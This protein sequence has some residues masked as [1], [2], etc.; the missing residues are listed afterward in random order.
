MR[1]VISSM[2]NTG[3]RSL[4]RMGV[5]VLCLMCVSGLG[6]QAKMTDW[7]A[8]LWLRESVEGKVALVVNMFT[9][10]RETSAAEALE[11]LLAEN[12]DDKEFVKAT[13]KL[14]PAMRRQLVVNPTTSEAARKL[15][16]RVE[17]AIANLRRDRAY[18][19][20]V[21]AQI[22]DG[23][24]QRWQALRRCTQLGEYAVPAMVNMLAQTE[25]VRLRVF[26]GNALVLMGPRAV[27]PLSEAVRL[28]DPVA[29]TAVC[30][31]LGNIQNE[32]ALGALSE[33]LADRDT[34]RMVRQAAA[35][36][37]VLI[38][39]VAKCKVAIQKSPASYY[40][41][42]AD[43]YLHEADFVLPTLPEKTLPI[44]NWSA[45]EKRIVRQDVSAA[46]YNEKMAAKCCYAGLRTDKTNT[47]LRAL[48][49]SSR[50][51]QKLELAGTAAADTRRDLNMA[52][53]AG[54]EQTLYASLGK[55]LADGDN[56]IAILACQTLGEVTTSKG[57]PAGRRLMVTNPLLGA[58]V[59]PSRPVRLSAARAL[60][61]Q[62][63]TRG[64]F[65]NID[66]I[67]PAL[68]WGLMYEL[69][70][71]SILVAHPS[72]AVTGTYRDVLTGL[73]YRM[74]EALSVEALLKRG[75]DL[76]KPAAVIM[77]VGMFES[78]GQL[79]IVL[80]DASIPILLIGVDG[81]RP[82]SPEA[83]KYVGTAGLLRPAP[84]AAE[85]KGR[86]AGVLDAEAE[87]KLIAKLMPDISKRSAK[88]LA[89]INAEVAPFRMGD[90]VGVLRQAL[91]HESDAVRVP[92]LKALGAI[93]ATEAISDILAVAVTPENSRDVRLAALGALA[94]VFESSEETNP[95]V[96]R[97]LVPMT[98]SEDADI[99]FAAARAVTLAKFDPE[100]FADLVVKK[101]VQEIKAGLK[102]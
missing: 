53:L 49:V 9:G 58:L 39:A 81:V 99:A 27:R 13:D 101:R 10:G 51:A 71:K 55:A 45:Q 65:E 7:E 4:F 16:D 63:P 48:L 38:H 5:V 83:K 89:A 76:P 92:S 17:K 35:R 102:K 86:L 64:G 43:A 19:D 28:D 21:V 57:L 32:L 1:R 80:T 23:G 97:Q 74:E 11:K 61:A 26:V 84:T 91:S 2:R 82:D 56:G 3:A 70:A 41:V 40:Y 93:G 54:G 22:A 20:S 75:A 77:D 68:S 31:A 98:D 96:F 12:L 42:L 24:E 90:V 94:A 78:L 47:A 46:L 18:V 67:L 60:T 29:A 33:M 59:C 36:A 30:E 44:W 14:T 52:V 100:Q 95:D 15:L 88:A 66:M 79:R 69:S 87:A 6:L 8:D 50:F 62:A 72:D 37:I 25:D 85:L 34:P 73:G